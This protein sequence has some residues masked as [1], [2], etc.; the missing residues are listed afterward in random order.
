MYPWVQ[1]IREV[2][3]GWGHTS[4]RDHLVVLTFWLDRLEL[5]TRPSKDEQ[6]S[7]RDVIGK[8]A[9]RLKF[10]SSVMNP[11]M[12]SNWNA[13]LESLTINYER[14]WFEWE[15][16]VELT[17]LILGAINYEH[18]LSEICIIVVEYWLTFAP[19]LL[20][21]NSCFYLVNLYDW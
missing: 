20:K 9:Y 10:T 13:D 12:A 8:L 17:C 7:H 19:S 15:R 3:G 4:Q 5:G 2:W 11:S 21:L 6:E 18:C 1:T 16:T 14:Y